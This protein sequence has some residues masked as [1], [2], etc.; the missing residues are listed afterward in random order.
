MALQIHDHVFFN[1]KNICIYVD[2]KVTNQ[3]CTGDV[4]EIGNLPDNEEIQKFQMILKIF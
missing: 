1:I 2:D 3:A 4:Q